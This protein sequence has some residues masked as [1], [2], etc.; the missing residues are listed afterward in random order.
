M[1]LPYDPAGIAGQATTLVE[2]KAWRPA[3]ADAAKYDL[4]TAKALAPW[5]RLRG[6]RMTV[7]FAAVHEF[8]FLALSGAK[9]SPLPCQL[10]GAKPTC[11]LMR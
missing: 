9:R 5:Q 3:S 7:L 11:E 6:D 2:R 4:K 8:P 1:V 10:S